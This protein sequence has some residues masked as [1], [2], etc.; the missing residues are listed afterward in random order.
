MIVIGGCCDV[1]DRTMVG[2]PALAANAA[3]RTGTGLA[4]I[5]AD[6]RLLPAIMTIAPSATGIALQVDSG[7]ALAPSQACHALGTEVDNANCLA[8]GPGWGVGFDR[9]QVLVWLLTQEETPVVLDADGIN[10][11]CQIPSVG[12]DLHAATI[13]TPHPG[14]FARL[15]ESLEIKPPDKAAVNPSGGN[16]EESSTLAAQVAQRLGCVVVLKSAATIVTDGL[17]VWVHDQPNPV[18]ATAGSGDVLTGTIAGLVAQ[19]FKPHMGPIG[20]DKFGKFDLFQCA[21]WGVTIHAKAAKAWS[22]QHGQAGMLAEDL[23]NQLPDTIA[24]IRAGK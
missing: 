16:L 23:I 4:K 5:A 7:G 22:E 1:N 20:P 8:V 17:R 6:A 19:F 10:N 13:I 12:L 11:L 21:Q 24:A 15:C 14:E 2:A 18:L 9:Q 3:L